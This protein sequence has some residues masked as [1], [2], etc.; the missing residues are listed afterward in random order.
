M[1]TIALKEKRIKTDLVLPDSNIKEK[2]LKLE[3]DYY[4][5]SVVELNNFCSA[6]TEFQTA[7]KK[8]RQKPG[9]FNIY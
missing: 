9:L 5:H 8:S 1:Y 4:F 7:I 3:S 6:L 2:V